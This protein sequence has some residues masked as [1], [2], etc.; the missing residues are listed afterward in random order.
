MAK[1]RKNKNWIDKFRHKYRLVIMQEDTFEEKLSFRLSR[2]NVFVVTAVLAILLIFSTIY[3]IAYT[4]LKQYIPGYSNVHIQEDLYSQI[5]KTDSLERVIL[6]REAYLYNL[7]NILEGNTEALK[8]TVSVHIDSNNVD[9]YKNIR[10]DRSPEDSMLREEIQRL[11]KYNL[12]Y[13]DRGVEPNVYSKRASIRNFFFFT[14]LAG[15]I[16]NGFNVEKE[17]YGVDIV[18]KENDVVK[19]TLD[20]RIVFS[21]WTMRTGY[22]IIIMHENNLISVYKH[23]A[24]LLKRLG[25]IVKAGEPIAISGN[26]GELTTGPHLHFE[27][28]Y[29]GSPENP[30]EYMSF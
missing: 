2:L 14:P 23:N 4:P 24:S 8:D 25:E 30:R 17:H 12:V 13:Y 16:T 6:Q 26:T 19:A 11:D 22:V 20:G 18:G 5:K 21:N 29:N 3:I 27:I 9:K 1:K 10:F 28:W 15:Q 7:K